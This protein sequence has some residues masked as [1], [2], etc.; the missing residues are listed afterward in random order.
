MK[1]QPNYLMPLPVWRTS[2]TLPSEKIWFS[3]WGFPSISAIHPTVS[4]V[5][6]QQLANELG[7]LPS[8]S[9]PQPIVSH[10]VKLYPIKTHIFNDIRFYPLDRKP[11]WSWL[12]RLQKSHRSHL[13]KS[14]FICFSRLSL[15]ASRVVILCWSFWLLARS[16]EHS[17]SACSEISWPHVFLVGGIPTQPLW[18]MMEWKSVGMMT[19]PIYGK[20]ELM[21]Q[22][23]NQFFVFW[24]VLRREFSGMIHNH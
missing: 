3:V 5:I 20:I 21:F 19:F 14:L 23:T 2:S 16:K 10:N 17:S 4:L 1:N 13:F 11:I 24:C 8:Q 22:T 12:F 7:A 18:K 9:H 6:N 15:K